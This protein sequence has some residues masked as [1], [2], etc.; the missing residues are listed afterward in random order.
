MFGLN[1]SPPKRQP[2][3]FAFSFVEGP[4]F[5][6]PRSSPQFSTFYPG[7]S[8]LSGQSPLLFFHETVGISALADPVSCDFLTRA[9]FLE[10]VFFQLCSVPASFLNSGSCDIRSLPGAF[11]LVFGALLVCTRVLF[12]SRRFLAR[13]PGRTPPPPEILFTRGFCGPQT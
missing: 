2:A 9:P 11:C 6:P 4:T 5:P 1:I 13:F 7:V 8:P 10:V 12:E 3:T